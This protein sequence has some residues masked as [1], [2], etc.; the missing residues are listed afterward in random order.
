MEQKI[1]KIR[2]SVNYLTYRK[3]TLLAKLMVLSFGIVCF[4]FLVNLPSNDSHQKFFAIQPEMKPS[5]M[6]DQDSEHIASHAKETGHTV[7]LIKAIPKPGKLDTI[8]HLGMLIFGLL[9]MRF[10][11]YCTISKESLLII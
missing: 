7:P 3:N 4:M 5:L 10:S 6:E 11:A 9:F 2:R 1:S 8:P